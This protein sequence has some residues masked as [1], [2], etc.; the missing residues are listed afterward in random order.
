MSVG[1]SCKNE[2]NERKVNKKGEKNLKYEVKKG[3]LTFYDDF[4][5]GLTGANVVGG[6]T[7]VCSTV[8]QFHAGDEKF[9]ILGC[10]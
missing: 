2:Q 6:N 10:L 7:F 5:L 4:S 8:S 9:S 1:L 3:Q